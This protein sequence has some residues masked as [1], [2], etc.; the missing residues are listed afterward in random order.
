MKFHCFFATSKLHT[1]KDSVVAQQ[2]AERIQEPRHAKSVYIRR[3]KRGNMQLLAH[4]RSRYSVTR[5]EIQ[6]IKPQFS[7]IRALRRGSLA[8]EEE[9][10]EAAPVAFHQGVPPSSTGR[11]PSDANLAVKTRTEPMQREGVPRHRVTKR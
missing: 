9:V 6:E 11:W 2:E 4:V 7:R 10:L 5:Q 3:V 8:V 1:D